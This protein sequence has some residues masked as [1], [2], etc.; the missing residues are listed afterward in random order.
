V[1]FVYLLQF[2]GED[3]SFFEHSSFNH[4]RS[5]KIR[6]CV[7]FFYLEVLLDLVGPFSKICKFFF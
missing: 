6:F 4:V 3:L 7:H 5:W 1:K 2:H